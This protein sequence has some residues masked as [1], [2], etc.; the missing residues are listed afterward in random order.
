M[1][2][3]RVVQKRLIVCITLCLFCCSLFALLVTA[4]VEKEV[5]IANTKGWKELYLG[6][7]YA[8]LLQ[9]E[10]MYFENLGDAEL[11]IKTLPTSASIILLESRKKPV[12]K[13]YQAFLKVNGYEKPQ[14]TYFDDYNDLQQQLW[15]TTDMEGSIL[16]DER[17]GMEAV[18][19]AP[20]AIKERLAPYFMNEK[21]KDSLSE[22]LRRE[23]NLILLGHFPIRW[24][25]Q[26]D[27]EKITSQP[28]EN[29]VKITQRAYKSLDKDWGILTDIEHID[30]QSLGQGLP[31]FV[32]FGQPEEYAKLINGSG[33]TKF[34]AIG[35][36]LAE[37]ASQIKA[38][39]PTRLDILLKFAKTMTN[40][41]GLD[42]KIL[43]I[44]TIPIDYPVANLEYVKTVY[45]PSMNII[46]VTFEN[47]GNVPVQFFTAVE[48][49][50]NA[51]TDDNIHAVNPGQKATIPYTLGQTAQDV[52]TTII[53][54]RFGTS[55]PFKRALLSEQGTPILT[56]SAQQDDHQENTTF[57]LQQAVYDDTQGIL[58]LSI[59]N[60]N[61]YSQV[62][63]AE[64][65]VGEENILSS[66]TQT[67]NADSQ[68][69]LEIHT[70]YLTGEDFAGQSSYVIDIYHGEKDTLKKTPVDVEIE[71]RRTNPIVGN[72]IQFASEGAILPSLILIAA[73]I[74]IIIIRKR[75]QK[76]KK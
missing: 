21:N 28:E 73:I 68:G 48:F 76:E 20:L 6:S 46:A 61:K 56:K 50:E 36:D 75:S 2:K 38:N 13:N 10:F 30:L 69:I 19:A 37:V 14:L 7:V 72:V 51:L 40:I 60:P 52:S 1:N 65:L 16:L 31:I 26:F 42:G 70:P 39:S 62:L 12:V 11:K 33:I 67:I 4:Q 66:Q 59:T 45:Y 64:L 41:E 24:V 74:A 22:D 43:N 44:D 71:I 23:K 49:S 57:I 53:N 35:G 54:T 9:R 18:A 34:E 5:V 58:S 63:R 47:I 32:Y 27:G 55:I 17:F 8:G 3:K 15:E 25:N 29:L